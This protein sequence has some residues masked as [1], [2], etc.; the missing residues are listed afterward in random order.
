VL[1]DVEI[2]G[3]TVGMKSK[4]EVINEDDLNTNRDR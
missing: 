3:N 4:M 2:F 1:K